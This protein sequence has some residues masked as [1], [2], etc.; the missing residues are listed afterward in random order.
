MSDGG[1]DRGARD[2]RRAARLF[3]L[4][5]EH[6]R[7][8]NEASRIGDEMHRMRNELARLEAEHKEAE[9]QVDLAWK[10]VVIGA[11]YPWQLDQDEI[12]ADEVEQ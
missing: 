7:A 11:R 9:Y 12:L 3:G 6:R 5:K 1:E 4:T 10:R 8:Q 2:A